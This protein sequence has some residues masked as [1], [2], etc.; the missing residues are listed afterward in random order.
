VCDALHDDFGLQPVLVGA[1]SERERATAHQIRAH[2]RGSA[3]VDALGAGGLR[4]LVG[5]LDGA[6]LVVSLDTAPLHMSVALGRPVIA[7]MAQADPRRTGPYRQFHD[8]VV[9]AFAEPGDPPDEVLWVRRRGRMP[10]ISVPQVLERVERWR[11]AY[12]P[13]DRGGIHRGAS[14]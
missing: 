1:P 8:L 4:G 12:A 3:P 13:H 14:G 6:A 7:L 9:N 11:T 5:I 10:R 2:A